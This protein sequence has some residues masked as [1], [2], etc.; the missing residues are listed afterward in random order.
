MSSWQSANLPI[1]NDGA[2]LGSS[3]VRW[4]DLFL[5]EGG[6]INWDNGDLTLTQT[7]NVL[8][9][10]GA[11][12]FQPSAD[13]GAALGAAGNGWS[14]LF[15]AEGAV[16]NWDSSDFTI[17]QAG[18]L[19]TL[20]GGQ[21]TFGANTAYFTE[22]DNGNSGTTKTIDWTLSNKQKITT[23][24]SCTLTF[25]APGGPC[26]LV[27]RIVHEASATAYTYT[28]PATVKWPGGSANKLVT[29]NTSGAVDIVSFYYDG[30]NYNAVGTP[31]F[32]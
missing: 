20:A 12:N 5:A 2:A 7:G 21:V 9:I 17:T 23:T 32:S 11:T 26:N 1:S 10:G 25:T 16:I 8:A 18:N 14:D 27:L 28:Y 19:L 6:V 13:D 4:S 30:T 22:T 24:G 3:S 15:L 31:N 29:T